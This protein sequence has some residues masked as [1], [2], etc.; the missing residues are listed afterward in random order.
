MSISQ[1]F[2]EDLISN[3]ILLV[4]GLG[5]VCLRDFCKRV[6]RSDC[7]FDS[8]AGGLKIKLPTWHEPPEETA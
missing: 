4:V 1:T 7:V 2:T 5:V 8:E 6:S 3:A